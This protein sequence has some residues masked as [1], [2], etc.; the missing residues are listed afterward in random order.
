M[1]LNGKRQPKQSGTKQKLK[2]LETQ[3]TN[4]EMATRISQMM[5][6]QMLDQFQGLRRDLDNTMGILND[7]QYRTQAMMQLGNF[8]IDELNK[9]AEQ[10]KLKDYMKASDAED[11]AKGFTVDNDGVVDEKSVVIITSTTNGDE[12]RG[13]FRSKF[14]MDECQTETL[15][16]QLLGKKVGDVVTEEINGD[17][18]EIT[19]LEL[20]RQ[21]EEA[22]EGTNGETDESN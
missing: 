22:T 20:R 2:E 6:K 19:I 1:N 5:I 13:I 14:S 8:D 3:L 10:F 4:S 9:L 16:E 12:D 18:H 17:T 7:F 21:P 15:R 11:E